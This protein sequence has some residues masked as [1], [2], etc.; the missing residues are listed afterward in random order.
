MDVAA[1]GLQPGQP[2]AG[3][4]LAKFGDRALE[5]G[6]EARRVEPLADIVLGGILRQRDALFRRL[7]L[8]LEFGKVAVEGGKLA[9]DG[10]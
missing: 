6:H 5:R 7:S 9:V 3:R 4:V 10:G 8:T 1:Q 2:F